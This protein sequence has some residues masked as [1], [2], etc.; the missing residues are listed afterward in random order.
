MKRLFFT[1]LILLSNISISYSAEQRFSGEP[2]PRFASLSREH[3]PTRF[4]PSIKY[5]VKYEYHSKF[6]PVKI[7]NEYYGWYQIRD[8]KGDISWVY[9]GYLSK[10]N[11][12]TVIHNKTKLFEQPRLTSNVLAFVNVGALFRLDECDS[13]FCRVDTNFNGK[14]YSGFILQDNLWGV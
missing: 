14:S 3:T 11:Y 8:R 13:G 1:I 4:G 12:V 7:I 9:N 2:L 6:Q 10:N 5:P